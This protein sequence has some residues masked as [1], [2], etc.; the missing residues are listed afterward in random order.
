MK[1]KFALVIL[2]TFIISGCSVFYG[3]REDY[4]SVKKQRGLMKDYILWACIHEAYGYPLSAEDISPS[5]YVDLSA[6]APEAFYEADV[7]AKKICGQ[8]RAFTCC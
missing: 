7:F 5:G 3:Q 4:S 1:F 2:T 8:H 6:Y